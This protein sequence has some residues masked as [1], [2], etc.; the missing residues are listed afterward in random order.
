MNFLIV[1]SLCLLATSKVTLQSRFGKKMSVNAAETVIFNALIF[2][3]ASVLFCQQIPNA[4]PQTWLFSA[5][6]ALFTVIFQL[7]YTKALSIGNVSLTVMMVNLSMLLPVLVSATF[8]KEALSYARIIGIFLTVLSFT[9]CVEIK[10]QSKISK[11]WLCLAVVAMSAN[12]SIGITQKIFG[13]SRF[14]TEKEAFVACSYLLAFLITICIFTV[15]RIRGE[16]S[17]VYKNRSLYLFSASVGI[18]LAGFQ[19]LNTYAIATLDGTFLFPVY[20]GGSIILSTLAG[21]IFFKDR[22]LPKQWISILIGI[23]AVVIMNF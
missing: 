14:H 2:L 4:S 18:I 23:V 8:Y 1:L 11:K 22:F 19:W 16:S 13:V 15:I 3:T 21:I 20:S 12:G 5:A 10:D 6:F 17:A 9:L 7:S